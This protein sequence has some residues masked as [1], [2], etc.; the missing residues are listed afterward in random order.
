MFDQ[1]MEIIQQQGQQ[2]VVA[3]PEVPNE[4]NQEVM[5]EAANSIQG[6]MQGLLQQGGP[7]AL[8]NLFEGVQNGDNNNPAVQ[9]MT[10]NFAGS[11]MEKFGLNSGAAKALAVSLIPVV[12]G[13]LMNRAKDPNDNGINIG[14]ILGS[15]MG[16]AAGSPGSVYGGNNAAPQGMPQQAGAGGDVMGQL[17]QMGTKF[18]LDKNGDGK[19]DLSDLMKMFA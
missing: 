17:S 6:Q 15:L 10:N 14:S 9:G 11:I 16:G 19:T 2:T 18:G 8:K 5:R 3:N 7:A 13:K 4:H 1:L 12:L